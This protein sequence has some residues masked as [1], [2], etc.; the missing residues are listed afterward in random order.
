M[1]ESILFSKTVRE[2]LTVFVV[3]PKDRFYLR[4]LCA[5]IKSSPRPVQ[6]G[7]MKL[8]KAGILNFQKEANIKFYSLNKKSP[9]YHEIKSIILKT[10]AIGS[11]LRKGLKGLKGVKYVFIYGSTAK[12]KERKGSDIDICVI[13]RPDLTLLSGIAAQLEER[14]K[15]EV[16]TVTFTPEEFEKAKSQKKAFVMDIIKSKKI[17]LIGKSNEL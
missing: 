4:Q 6:L 14:L 2:L 15:R 16:S 13:G 11:V 8:Q 1:K 5:I 9:I 10:E 12:D 7:L 3:N 17:D